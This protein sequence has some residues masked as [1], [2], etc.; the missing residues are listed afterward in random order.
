MIGGQGSR[1]NAH[2]PAIT[3]THSR[4]PTK[5]PGTSVPAPKATATP[6]IAASA[7]KDTSP[8]PAPEFGAHALR[9]ATAPYK[10][11][12]PPL[13]RTGIDAKLSPPR[14]T[15]A[16][17]DKLLDSTELLS[18]STE[19]YSENWAS[20]SDDAA[21]H[22]SDSADTGKR[23]DTRSVGYTEGGAGGYAIP[24]EDTAR[25]DRPATPT[26]PEDIGSALKAG[27]GAQGEVVRLSSG[28]AFKVGPKY[29]HEATM[30]AQFKGAKGIVQIQLPKAHAISG[31]KR[32]TGYTMECGAGTLTHSNVHFPKT[33]DQQLSAARD[34]IYGWRA[35]AEKGVIHRDIKPQNIVFFP[36]QGWKIVDFGLAATR[37][38]IKEE[39]DEVGAEELLLT[40]GTPGYFAPESSENIYSEK[41][42][43]FSLGMTLVQTVLELTHAPILSHIRIDFKYA[44]EIATVNYMSNIGDDSLYQQ[45]CRDLD[46]KKPTHGTE[47]I[48]FLKAMIHPDPEMRPSAVEACDIIDR[49]TA[50]RDR[51]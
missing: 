49:L 13:R 51:K 24:V 5:R 14:R 41:S 39:R 16:L 10:H 6:R 1:S 12:S 8:A 45:V 4:T 15:E 23:S 22:A 20:D 46:T 31:P 37:A 18:N 26:I 17:T 34:I 3:G 33:V 50:A 32:L 38:H 30:L 7:F 43:G 36:T 48:D 42:D 28:S 35:M 29:W 44:I 9:T 11:E 21:A 27:V 19:T 25:S 47:Y 40:K 2:L